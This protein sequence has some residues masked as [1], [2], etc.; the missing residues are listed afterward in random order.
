MPASVVVGLFADLDAAN[1]A[2]RAMVDAR[3][4]AGAVA[5]LPPRSVRE[6][7]LMRGVLL[8][9]VTG[10]LLGFVFGGL[11]GYLSTFDHTPLG[12][13]TAGVGVVVPIALF[14]VTGA[15]A[16]ATA[17]GLFGMDAVSDPAMYVIQ[18]VHEGRALTSVSVGPSDVRRAEAAL[19]TAGALDV[20]DLGHGEA[21]HRITQEVERRSRPAPAGRPQV[22]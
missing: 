22:T 21:A 4:P 19:S 9:M 10:A 11:L 20:L 3:F 17:G 18:E 2:A 14:A 7:R 6:R 1:R 8:G 16:G 15:A 12:S 5:V 13:V